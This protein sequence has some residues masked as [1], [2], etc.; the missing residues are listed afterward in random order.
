MKKNL[1][2]QRGFETVDIVCP[3]GPEIPW[4]RCRRISTTDPENWKICDEE[5]ASSPS[6]IVPHRSHVKDHHHPESGQQEECHPTETHRGIF[7]IVQEDQGCT[8]EG[9]DPSHYVRLNKHAQP[10]DAH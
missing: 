10:F 5:V 8:H 1:D 9:H 3:C 4:K 2:L 6:H 7:G